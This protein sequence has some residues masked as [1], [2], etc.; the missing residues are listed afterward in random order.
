[1]E[2]T[3]IS[4]S[5]RGFRQTPAMK[6]GSARDDGTIRKSGIVTLSDSEGK[7]TTITYFES[8]EA[9]LREVLKPLFGVKRGEAD[10]IDVPVRKSMG[11]NTS[12]GA[13]EAQHFFQPN[14]AELIN[15]EF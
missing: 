13:I 7:E 15:E 14:D 5:V 4:I 2:D 6:L 12:T 1:M 3:I 9:T 8:N 10:L 11:V